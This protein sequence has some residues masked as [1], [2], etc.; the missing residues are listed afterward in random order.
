MFCKSGSVQ[1]ESY[2]FCAAKN[3]WR[4]GTFRVYSYLRCSF[5][6]LFQALCIK[7]RLFYGPSFN[8]TV[9]VK[10]QYLTPCSQRESLGPTITA[11]TRA[12]HGQCRLLSVPPHP[13]SPVARRAAIHRSTWKS[14]SPPAIK[15]GRPPGPR[16]LGGQWARPLPAGSSPTAPSSPPAC[17][18]ASHAKDNSNSPRA[19]PSG[20]QP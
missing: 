6:L 9:A 15:A 8:V 14:L 7:R 13:I 17:P 3:V 20:P 4:D 11:P 5:L 1:S 10:V 19:S 2:L 18:A 12:P 16:R